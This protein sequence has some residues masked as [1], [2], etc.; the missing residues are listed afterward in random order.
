MLTPPYPRPPP[1]PQDHGRHPLP[2]HPSFPPPHPPWSLPVGP[3]YAYRFSTPP[4][5]PP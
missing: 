4:R 5:F 3:L 1:L 2:P